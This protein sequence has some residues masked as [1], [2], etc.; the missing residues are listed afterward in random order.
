MVDAGN[1]ELDQI[2]GVWSKLVEDFPFLERNITGTAR[3][4]GP[5]ERPAAANAIETVTSDARQVST[6]KFVKYGRVVVKKNGEC[7]NALGQR[8]SK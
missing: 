3:D 6:C 2:N 5:Y 4:L 8:I 7:Y 1:A